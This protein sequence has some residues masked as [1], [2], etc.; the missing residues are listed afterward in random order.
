[1]SELFAEGPNLQECS[2]WD[3]KPAGDGPPIKIRMA[4]VDAKAA[5]KNDAQRYRFAF[6]G[7]PTPTRAPLTDEERAARDTGFR[8]QKLQAEREE[9]QTA[10]DAVRVRLDA[11]IA[12]LEGR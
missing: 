11:Q 5:V 6:P 4:V 1:M 3:L 8:V 9:L 10:F 7:D 2:V 12:A